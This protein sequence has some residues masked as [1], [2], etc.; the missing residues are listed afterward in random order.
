VKPRLHRLRA[1][2]IA[3]FRS[4]PQNSGLLLF[5]RLTFVAPRILLVHTEWR[6][7]NPGLKYLI[8]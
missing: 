5:L 7:N 8:C 2:V 1:V 3:V 4:C 6:Q